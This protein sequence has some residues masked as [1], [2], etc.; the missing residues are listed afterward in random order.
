MTSPSTTEKMEA[1]AL[2]LKQRLERYCHV[3]W[4]APYLAGERHCLFNLYLHVNYCTPQSS[5]IPGDWVTKHERL[6]QSVAR[7]HSEKGRVVHI[8]QENTMRLRSKNGVTIHG[9]CD[10]VVSETNSM[11][12]IISDAKTG[13]PRGK[14]RAQ[15][16]TYMAL[17]P[18]ATALEGVQHPP[19]GELVYANGDRVE[20]PAL[21]A[22]V[23]FQ[24][25]LSD[26]LSLTAGPQPEPSP[27]TNECRFCRLA[28]ICPHRISEEPIQETVSW[29]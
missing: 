2:N 1:Q 17:A 14:D 10:V 24:Q 18:Y 19:C 28:E 13:R 20:I 3:T 4:L 27:S 25:Q 22:G 23:A 11:P 6:L 26:L 12:G 5:G 21:E 7:T 8:E 29:L 15:V 9:Q 16:L